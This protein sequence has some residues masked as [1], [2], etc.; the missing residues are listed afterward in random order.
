[1]HMCQTTQTGFDYEDYGS[2]GLHP[3]FLMPSPVT[4][5]SDDEMDPREASAC[6]PTAG[7][8]YTGAKR[9]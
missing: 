9:A 3:Q 5:R 4:H 7:L 6:V 2:W 8:S 1:M